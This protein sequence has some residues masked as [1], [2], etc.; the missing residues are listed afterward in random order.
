VT[1]TIITATRHHHG[2]ELIEQWFGDRVR[3]LALSPSRREPMTREYLSRVVAEIHEGVQNLTFDGP[4]F[5]LL[6]G[7]PFLNSVAMFALRRRIQDPFLV[8]V[9]NGVD[10]YHAWNSNFVMEY[11]TLE[12]WSQ[13]A[14]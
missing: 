9:F 11:P 12:S 2:R 14:R 7:H 5:F 1:V 10:D 8:L 13:A 6:T 3:F 4:I